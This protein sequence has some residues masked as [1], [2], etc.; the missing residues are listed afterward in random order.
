MLPP[1]LLAYSF[2]LTLYRNNIGELTP[3]VLA[4]PMVTVAA[5]WLV[6]YATLGFILPK[7][8]KRSVL[9]ALMTVCIFSFGDLSG[10]TS[11]LSARM[12]ISGSAHTYGVLSLVILTILG[13]YR[14]LRIRK[15]MPDSLLGFLA[16]FAGVSVLIPL[17]H[18]GVYEFTRRSDAVV[19]S[20]FR[21]EQ[22]QPVP[23]EDLPDIYWIL[24]DGYGAPSVFSKYF[25]MD[26]SG[27]ERYLADKGFYVAGRGTSNY[28]KTYLSV[29]STLNMEYL[30]YLSVHKNSTQEPLVDPLIKNNTVLAFLKEK[31]YTYYQIGSWWRATQHNRLAKKNFNLDLQNPVGLNAFNS[32]II[33]ST[34]LRPMIPKSWFASVVTESVEDKRRRIE[35]E[36][37]VF[38]EVVPLPGPKFVFAHIIAPHG[39][40]VFGPDCEYI[41]Q[42]SLWDK[43]DE[44]GYTRQVSCINKYLKK[45]VDTILAKSAK[46]PV[47]LLQADEGAS[48]LA[49]QLVPDNNW[50]SAS[51]EVLRRKFPIL[52]AYYLPGEAKKAQLYDTVTPVNSFRVIL[53]AY[54]NTGIPLLPDRNYIIPDK[55]HLFEFIDVTE[56]VKGQ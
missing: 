38:D 31:G 30:D 49:D 10:L 21:I 3:K 6:I 55:E 17:W 28:P 52:S 34:L 2:I 18:I 45:T 39:P 25:G 29:A 54:F 23:K 37:G 51:D 19:S 11:G 43:S 50:K 48:F 42:E 8:D 24:P 16:L 22:S 14:F 56:R 41:T 27:F 5:I 53:N 13:A 7:K 40:N 33:N 47:I 36:F 46:P 44:Y 32:I 9:F 1:L 15:T 4:V 12:G 35:Y 20:R 26:N